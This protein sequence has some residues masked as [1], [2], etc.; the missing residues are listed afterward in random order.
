MSFVEHLGCLVL[1]LPPMRQCTAQIPAAANMCL[2]NLNTEL[3]KQ[4]LGLE[5]GAVQLLQAFD[6]PGNHAQFQRILKELAIVTDGRY[7]YAAGHCSNSASGTHSSHRK[8]EMR[9]HWTNAEL[10][11]HPGPN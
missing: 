1:C 7:I 8:A 6:W 2:S 4:L 10:G 5:P 3:A 9:R 11:R